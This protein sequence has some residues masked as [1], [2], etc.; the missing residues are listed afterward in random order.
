MI[1][2]GKGGK[3]RMIPIHPDLELYLKN[4]IAIKKKPTEYLFSSIHSNKP[5]TNKNFHTIFRKTRRMSQISF[6]P[7]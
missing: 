1:I 4:Y 6:K 3:D 5:L 2:Q 7:H